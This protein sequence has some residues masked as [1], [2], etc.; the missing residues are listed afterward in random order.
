M[1]LKPIAMQKY[2]NNSKIQLN[3]KQVG[4]DKPQK[5]PYYGIARGLKLSF[6]VTFDLR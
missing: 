2:G 4:T 6:F 3:N 5:Q 1:G